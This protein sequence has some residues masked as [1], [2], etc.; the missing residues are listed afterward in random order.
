VDLGAD[1]FL[2]FDDSL[3]NVPQERWLSRLAPARQVVFRS[4][5][6]A[7][8][9]V[10]ARSGL[11]V[12]LLPCYIADAEPG[13]VRL[14]GPEPVEHELW[15]LVHGDLRR[16]PRVKAVI[17]WIDELVARARPALVGRP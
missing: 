17:E 15:L 12:A 7:S 4:N 2:G 10:A 5:S 16:S 9:V 6:T 1:R 11:G 14:G 8:L 3:A 13:L